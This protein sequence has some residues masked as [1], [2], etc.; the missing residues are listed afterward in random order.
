MHLTAESIISLTAAIVT[1]LLAAIAI[2][3][4]NFREWIALFFFQGEIDLL[5]GSLVVESGLLDYPVRILPDLYDTSL[6]FELW[7]LPILCILYNQIINKRS[8]WSM[9]Y[10]AM[11]FS[12]GI[13]G[14]E[15][16]IERNT[17]LIA[18]I[19]WSW[20]TTFITVTLAFWV[21]RAFVV[22]YRQAY[23]SFEQK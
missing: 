14:I 22:L 16:I 15:F 12:A 9:G 20:V 23:R 8:L 2:D 19:E 7:V 10:Y 5:L 17:N 13:T 1:L 18:Y 3:W 6:L 21:S 11:L 4:R